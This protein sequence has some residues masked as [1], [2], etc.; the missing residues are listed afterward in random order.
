MLVAAGLVRR[1]DLYRVLARIWDSRYVDPTEAVTQR[2]L[3]DGL[4]PVGGT[5]NHFRSAGLRA[6]DGW[7]RLN[8]TE[9]ADLGIRAAALDSTVG[10]I[11]STTFGVGLRFRRS[12]R[13]C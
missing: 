3:F 6:L 7:D 1:A 2:V 4:D 13:T 11:N 10:V 8:V 9:D 12:R 5:C